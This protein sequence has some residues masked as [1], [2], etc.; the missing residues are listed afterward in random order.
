M[1]GWVCSYRAIW[2]HPVFAGD[3]ERVGV[4][5]WMVKTAAWRR[6]RFRVGGD[7]IVLERGQLCV[8][9]AQICAETGISRKRLRAL[10]SEL[11]AE[12]AVGIKTATGRANGRSLITIRNYDKY[13]DVKSNEGQPEGQRRAKEGPTKEQGNNIRDTLDANA[14]NGADAPKPTIEVSVSSAAVWNAGKPFLASRG[15]ANPGSMIGR[16]LKSHTPVELLTALEAAQRSGTQ[17]PVSYIT[18]VL[19][20]SDAPEDTPVSELMAKLKAEGRL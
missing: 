18:A 9:Q 8:S 7:V 15:V 17:D 5:D 20:K 14:S 6:T 1:N 19:S 16:W 13:Q 12:N 4:W 3:A 11:E 2:S 10:L